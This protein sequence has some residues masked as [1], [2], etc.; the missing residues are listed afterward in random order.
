MNDILEKLVERFASK[1]TDLE[2]RLLKGAERA[3][4]AKAYWQQARL[5]RA[6]GQLKESREFRQLGNDEWANQLNPSPLSVPS[7]AHMGEE[8]SCPRCRDVHWLD[9]G[10]DLFPCPDCDPWDAEAVR[11]HHSGI[12]ETRRLQTLES[13][14]PGVHSTSREALA[15][16][17]AF[18]DGTGLP[19]LILSGPPGCGKTHLARG[20]AMKLI[21]SG[22]QAKYWSSIHFTTLLHSTQSSGATVNLMDVL[23]TNANEELL[24]LDD[25][26]VETL[27]PWVISQYEGLL[28]KRWDSL[29][30]TI[31]TTNLP[32]SEVLGISRRIHSR[33]NDVSMSVWVD[34]MGARDY[35]QVMR[36]SGEFSNEL[37]RA[38]GGNPRPRY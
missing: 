12:T 25:W 36:R 33:M 10:K 31:I 24:I 4:K 15:K 22:W 7:M 27:T 38:V 23:Q 29:A 30:P 26:G 21:K 35:R 34:M 3:K 13:Y 5:A 20:I 28:D 18:C 19:W 6:K 14:K 17:R 16:A 2:E 9:N 1:Y 11:L 32:A 8:S 37:S